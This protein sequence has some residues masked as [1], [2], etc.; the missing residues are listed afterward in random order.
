MELLGELNIVTKIVWF[1]AA[2]Q[3]VLVL[4]N[5]SP[6]YAWKNPLGFLSIIK[7]EYSLIESECSLMESENAS[8]KSDW[9][10]Q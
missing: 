3:R 6:V 10:V 5:M 2:A 7:Q 4:L 1:Q 8:F 9:R